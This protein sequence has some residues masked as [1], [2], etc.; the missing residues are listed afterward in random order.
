MHSY[1]YSPSLTTMFVLSTVSR[2]YFSI[3]L[4]L[5][6][7][8]PS[9]PEFIIPKK[10][11]AANRIVK[12]LHLCALFPAKNL[13]I[14]CKWL[15][16]DDAAH[17]CIVAFSFSRS[18]SLSLSHSLF[19]FLSSFSL[20]LF[21]PRPLS[22]FSLPLYLLYSLYRSL[23]IKE[24]AGAISW[25]VDSPNVR[26]IHRI[27]ATKR[28]ATEKGNREE[29]EVDSNR[30]RERARDSIRRRERERERER[31]NHVRCSRRYI[32]RN[33]PFLLF[34]QAPAAI[35]RAIEVALPLASRGK[36]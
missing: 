1:P 31:E 34:D 28:R 24:N 12:V 32:W 33:I 21:F 27:D 6:S 2:I 10:L 18:S 15:S 16:S 36:I 30:A 17:R 19:L 25:K 13:S 4:S 22:L 3:S 9:I 20:A 26:R 7:L 14:P 35:N 23:E 8:R 11:R 5:S 29:R